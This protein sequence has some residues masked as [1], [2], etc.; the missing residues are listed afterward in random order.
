MKQSVD[1]LEREKVQMAEKYEILIT[2]ANNLSTREK[3]TIEKC[4]NT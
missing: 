4:L 2:E 1:Q 3:C